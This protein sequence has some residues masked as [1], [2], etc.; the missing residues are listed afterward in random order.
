H[1]R[2]RHDRGRVRERPPRA[3]LRRAEAEPAPGRARIRAEGGT[4][5][6]RLSRPLLHRRGRPQHDRG[7]APRS[8]RLG[9]GGTGREDRRPR[10]DHVVLL[11]RSRREPHRAGD[12]R[13]N[14]ALARALPRLT[15]RARAEPYAIGSPPP[16]ETPDASEAHH[17]D[18][19]AF[20]KISTQRGA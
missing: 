5:D 20:P 8:W 2:P 12:R 6:T 14:L 9:R 17:S 3:L 19:K 1:E 10:A 18:R 16:S 4:A 15:P 11:P 13:K 7:L